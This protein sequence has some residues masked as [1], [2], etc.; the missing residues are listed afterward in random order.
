MYSPVGEIKQGAAWQPPGVP[1]GASSQ[2]ESEDRY[3]R[4]LK[5][6]QDLLCTHDLEGRLLSASN[7]AAS[8]L[9]YSVEELLRIPM[10]DFVAPE[11][12]SQFDSYLSEIQR[13]G[14]ARGLLAV[15][16]RSGERRIWEYHNTLQTEGVE[17]PVVLGLAHDVT[18]QRLA[19][20]LLQASEQRFRAVYEKSSIGIALVNLQDGRILQANEK[21]CEITGRSE[22]ELKGLDVCS[23]THPD[24]VALHLERLRELAQGRTECFEME[25]RYVRPDG[26]IRWG[27]LLVAPMGAVGKV[28]TYV[29][30]MVQDITERK[31]AEEALRESEARNRLIVD[32]ASEGIWLSGADLRTTFVNARMVEMLGYRQEEMLGRGFAD[33]LFEED[34]P[35]HQRRME[36]RHQGTSERY[37]RRLRGKDG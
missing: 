16:T 25:K 32:T 20:T 8:L 9:G 37:E 29:M 15:M 31:Q 6:S 12:R 17:A 4:L 11:F 21:Y 13:A 19:Q 5:H 26:S 10:A 27:N 7:A 1:P 30:G 23:I 2:A 28:P 24:D 3:R 35:D 22:Q 33:F 18:E 36:R 34:V 14:E